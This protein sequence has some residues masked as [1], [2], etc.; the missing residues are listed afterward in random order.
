MSDDEAI[1]FLK[2]KYGSA[3]PFCS[4]TE[5]EHSRARP[6]IVQYVENAVTKWQEIH[7]HLQSHYIK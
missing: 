2:E 1:S 7:A 3:W 5:E 6:L 4:L